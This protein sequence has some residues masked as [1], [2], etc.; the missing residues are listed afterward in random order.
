MKSIAKIA[1]VLL[2]AAFGAS[3]PALAVPLPPPGPIAG[4][5]AKL[6]AAYN[7]HDLDAYLALLA[8]DVQ[9]FDGAKQ[10]ASGRGEWALLVK[11]AL[12]DGATIQ[13]VAV[14]MAGDEDIFVVDQISSSS[15]T[16]RSGD[17]VVSDCCTWGR[18][19]RYTIKNG[20]VVSIHFL[21]GYEV[22]R[23]LVISH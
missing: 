17:H 4:L 3:L 2:V 9:V 19:I 21:T 6:K 10:V 13:P 5:N 20:K 8:P 14:A 12:N 22:G 7:A 23:P 18:L 1:A 16:N 15:V 11:P